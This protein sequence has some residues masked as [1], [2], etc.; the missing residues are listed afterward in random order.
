M[1]EIALWLVVALC[2]LAAVGVVWL[3]LWRVGQRKSQRAIATIP[4]NPTATI[5][6]MV[7]PVASADMLNIASPPNPLL[8]PRA[9]LSLISARSVLFGASRPKK[10]RPP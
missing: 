2:A 8:A 6:V 1:D 4:R 5:R 3:H 7:Q 9:V 10:E